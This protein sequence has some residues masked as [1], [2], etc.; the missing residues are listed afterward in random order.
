MFKIPQGPIEGDKGEEGSSEEHPIEL[1]GYAKSDFEALLK[2]IY[3][4]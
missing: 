4:R 3:P 1:H 2:V